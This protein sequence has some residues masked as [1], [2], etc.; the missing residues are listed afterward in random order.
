MELFTEPR[1]SVYEKSLHPRRDHSYSYDRLI[2]LSATSESMSMNYWS[3]I[4]QPLT[5]FHPMLSPPATISLAPQ[6]PCRALEMPSCFIASPLTDARIMTARGVCS[7]ERPTYERDTSAGSVCRQRR[8]SLPLDLT[9]S[10]PSDCV[11]EGTLSR[12]SVHM[13]TSKPRGS[14]TSMVDS[15]VTTNVVYSS[16]ALLFADNATSYVPSAV[17]RLFNSEPVT[18]STATVTVPAVSDG[19]DD[20]VTRLMLRRPGVVS[21]AAAAAGTV[22][23]A[24]AI[25]A[26][27]ASA[28][29]KWVIAI[30]TTSQHQ[31][32]VEQCPS[33]SEWF[34]SRADSRCFTSHDVGVRSVPSTA[35]HVPTTVTMS[36][37]SHL[38]QE[39]L[40]RPVASSSL[41]CVLSL[42]ADMSYQDLSQGS[43]ASGVFSSTA[44]TVMQYPQLSQV[45]DALAQYPQPSQVSDVM[46]YPQLSQVLSDI[47]TQYP[48]PSQ[49]TDTV[50]QYPQLSQVTY[51]VTQYPQPSQV[52]DAVAQYPQPSQVS[53]TVTQYPQ[54]SQVTDDVAQYPQPSQV[55]DAVT[56]Y[57]QPSQVSDAVTQYP[58]LSQ[59]SDTV[60]QYPQLS[61]V[62]ELLPSELHSATVQRPVSDDVFPV[63]SPSVRTKDESCDILQSKTAAADVRPI[64]MEVDAEVDVHPSTVEAGVGDSSVKQ[65]YGMLGSVAAG[66]SLCGDDQQLLA[67]VKQCSDEVTDVSC[68]LAAAVQ[69]SAV[70]GRATADD[71][72]VE[73]TIPFTGEETGLQRDLSLLNVASDHHAAV[74]S[75]EPGSEGDAVNRSFGEDKP[76]LEPDFDDEWLLNASDA[77]TKAADVEVVT[78]GAPVSTVGTP[79]NDIVDECQPASEPGSAAVA[80]ETSTPAQ[81]HSTPAVVKDSNADD[82]MTSSASTET[83]SDERFK[84]LMVKCTKALELCLARF[85][86]HYKSLYRLADV[87]FRCSC[88]KVSH[89]AH[90]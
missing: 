82:V 90:S 85:P 37:I 55:S 13:S 29:V 36:T 64:K 40:Q 45:S 21:T 34:S 76:D 41:Q 54:P 59:V 57:P 81:Q 50:T 16:A 75:I 70:L 79:S 14:V 53:D 78:G 12:Q 67:Q 15:A 39:S 84:E 66:S 61:D 11:F 18:H 65:C 42:E 6:M 25:E 38:V 46:Q 27:V 86:Q 69:N 48:Q 68:A 33:I 26:S 24:R 1:S 44:D 8:I 89:I 22:T 35:D 52:T 7:A 49:V 51:S 17:S 63:L 73:P 62:R 5:Y 9:I 28:D 23:G 80:M 43:I 87:Y 74:S 10:T 30:S 56:Q 4:S 71:V 83:D 31:N 32:A 60:M 58:Q 3:P 47:V 19:D 2:L 72:A 77:S 88:L 20:M